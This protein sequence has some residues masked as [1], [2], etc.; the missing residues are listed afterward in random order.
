MPA[1]RAEAVAPATGFR[2]APV[3]SRGGTPAKLAP[4]DPARVAREISAAI[5]AALSAE[6][7]ERFGGTVIIDTNDLGQDILGQDTGVTDAT[8]AEAFVDNPLGQ[9]REQTPF[10]IVVDQR[11]HHPFLDDPQWEPQ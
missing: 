7:A 1:V 3:W 2:P 11:G 8:L 10:A 4:A 5:R 6:S 9:A